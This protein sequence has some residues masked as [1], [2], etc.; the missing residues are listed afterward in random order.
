MTLRLSL[1][2]VLA[3]A[4]CAQQ[5]PQVHAPKAMF[6][7]SRICDDP[8]Y[9]AVCEQQVPVGRPAT[10]PIRVD[11]NL[12]TPRSAKLALRG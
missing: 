9:G 7:L 2:L 10:S 1:F 5:A 8:H 11:T 3:V 4:G 12:A 6:D